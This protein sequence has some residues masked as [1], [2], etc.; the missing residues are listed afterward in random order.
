MSALRIA[1]DYRPAL[2]G[3]SGIPRAVRE[4][5]RALAARGDVDL[6]L[7]A[8]SFGAARVAAH[9]PPE[10]SLWR[11]PVPGRALPALARIGLDAGRLC[12]GADVFHWTDY[13]HPPVART[14]RVVLTLHD[15]AFAADP[16]FHGVD[17]HTLATR[18]RAALERAAAIVCPTRATAADAERLLGIAPERLRVVPFGADHLTSRTADAE[19]D[20][21]PILMIG[22][23]EPRKNHRR[24]LAA[25][26][27]L[28]ANRPELVVVGARGW[29]RDETERAL[30]AAT[31]DGGVRWLERAGDDVLGDLLA[32]ASAVLYP[33]RLEGFGFPALEALAHGAPVV[34]GDTPALREVLG[35]HAEWC[36]PADVDS[37]ASALERALAPSA[38][39]PRRRAARRAHAAGYTWEDCAAQHAA[40]YAEVAQ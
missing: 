1:I 37:I 39:E 22:T 32:R 9:P 18:T 4:L 11:V 27:K 33:S 6:R 7:F 28:G 36:D 10:A 40:I 2:L 13:V 30:V 3:R 15:C 20:D 35:E 29:C 38:H 25:W 21:G 5:A 24:A 31:R 23:I 8:H 16:E 19:R 17:S 14:T 34:A 26:R 12:G